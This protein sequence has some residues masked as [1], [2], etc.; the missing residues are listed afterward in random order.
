MVSIEDQLERLAHLGLPLEP[1]ATV[2]S[3]L[4]QAGRTR[5]D[6]E[7]EPYLLLVDCAVEEGEQTSRA[8]F[9][10]LGSLGI[11]RVDDENSY[12]RA[13]RHIATTAGT[14]ERL[15][16]V[17]ERV[18]PDAPEGELEITIDGHLR[19]YDIDVRG[20]WADTLAL[21]E[22]VDDLAPPGTQ[23]VTLFYRDTMLFT[24]VEPAQT[25]ELLAEVQPFLDDKVSEALVGQRTATAAEP[26]SPRLLGDPADGPLYGVDLGPRDISPA[27]QE[28]LWWAIMAFVAVFVW[29]LSLL[30]EPLTGSHLTDLPV[31]VVGAAVI[32]YV[33]RAY[34]M[35]KRARRTAGG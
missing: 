6:W 20:D 24:W 1:H 10:R 7:R 22:I 15:S 34:A 33:L 23:G 11:E 13:T 26:G 2:D 18:D 28:Q 29:C 16:R 19:H 35:R 21:S 17:A 3:M 32:G 9:A 31:M 27:A 8:T 30:D 5:L 25:H 4:A 12:T 14:M